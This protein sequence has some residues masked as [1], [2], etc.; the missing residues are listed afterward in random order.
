MEALTIA[1]AIALTALAVAHWRPTITR[2]LTRRRRVECIICNRSLPA[3][4][5]HRRAET[6][7]HDLGGSGVIIETCRRRSCRR[8]AGT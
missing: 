5:A 7:H 3:A 6:E 8:A 4:R 2:H 1:L